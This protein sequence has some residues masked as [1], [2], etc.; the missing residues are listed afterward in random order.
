MKLVPVSKFSFVGVF[1]G[2]LSSPKQATTTGF[3]AAPSFGGAGFGTAPA[4]GS[5]AGFGAAPAFGATSP[6]KIFGSGGG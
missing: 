6:S 2:G 4:F 3:G 5:G 1:G